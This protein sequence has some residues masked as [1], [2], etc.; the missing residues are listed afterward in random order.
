MPKHR[1]GVMPGR[2]GPG[3]IS[4]Y[5][6]PRLALS[7]SRRNSARLEISRSP[8]AGGTAGMNEGMIR[9]AL[10]APKFFYRLSFQ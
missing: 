1:G 9:N 2:F 4:R 8:N 3:G 5:R 6:D 10:G 7:A